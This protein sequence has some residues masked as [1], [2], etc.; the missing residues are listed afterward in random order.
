[1]QLLAELKDCD[2]PGDF[3]LDL[4][5]VS[6]THILT[7]VN[8]T[9]SSS[10]DTP[11]VFSFAETVAETFVQLSRCSITSLLL[12]QE[13]TSWAAAE[14]EEKK[15]E[16][17]LDMSAMTLLEVEQQLLGRAARQ[18]QKLAL[19]QALAVMVESLQ[20]TVL[21]R[22]TTQVSG[23]ICTQQKEQIC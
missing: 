12:M 11:T 13:L 14:D 17:E 15:D 19:L 21:L 6:S 8:M 20:H 2:L 4:L 23:E 22:K 9:Q 1:M 3:F 10:I 7:P 16:Q 5:Q 18:G